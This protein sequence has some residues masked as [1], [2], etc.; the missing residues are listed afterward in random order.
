ME[1]LI[2]WQ[3]GVEAGAHAMPEMMLAE[4][5]WLM[6]RRL[7]MP[8]WS[9][10]RARRDVTLSHPANGMAGEDD[11]SDLDDVEIGC[12]VEMNGH[13]ANDVGDMGSRH[14]I[15]NGGELWFEAVV[16]ES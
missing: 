4:A 13:D 11:A 7:R 2:H 8:L 1:R 3:P 5:G 14:G 6:M 15:D 9:L 10:R 16:M 12:A